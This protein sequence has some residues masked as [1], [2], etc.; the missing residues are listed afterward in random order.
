MNMT[1]TAD[2]QFALPHI[3]HVAVIE[4]AAA[5]HTRGL[6]AW[7]CAKEAAKRQWHELLCNVT[8]LLTAACLPVTPAALLLA[9]WLLVQLVPSFCWANRDAIA[10]CLYEQTT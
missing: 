2:T 6:H 3:P 1:T 9:L 10:M 8:Y 7:G 4:S 5:F